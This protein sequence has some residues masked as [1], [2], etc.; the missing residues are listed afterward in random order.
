MSKKKSRRDLFKNARLGRIS[1]ELGLKIG[2]SEKSIDDLLM[3]IF[4]DFQEHF[5]LHFQLT[6]QK[7]FELHRKDRELINL[8]FFYSQ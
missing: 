5:D 6:G 3:K 1:F 4:N 8:P 2:L 7:F